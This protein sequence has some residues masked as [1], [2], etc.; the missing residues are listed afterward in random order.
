MLYFLDLLILRKIYILIY[1]GD[2]FDIEQLYLEHISS[3]NNKEFYPDNTKI[4][5]NSQITNIF[6]FNWKQK[7]NE[8]IGELTDMI[9]TNDEIKT[10]NNLLSVDTVLEKFNN[11][12]NDT[13][14]FN[15]MEQIIEETLNESEK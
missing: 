9:K 4:N 7:D 3:N 14:Y 13:D 6:E 10:Y 8:Y 1:L 2:S 5:I 15:N 11:L 12:I